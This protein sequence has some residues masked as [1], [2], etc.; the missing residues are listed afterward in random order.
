MLRGEGARR[1][2]RGRADGGADLRLLDGNPGGKPRAVRFD[3]TYRGYWT[4]IGHFIHSPFY[5]YAYAFGDCLVNALYA[6]FQRNPD[7]FQE[8]YLT[9]LASGGRYRHKE[10][11]AP[12]GLDASDPAFWN[13][14][15]DII[16]GM[17]D[18]LEGLDVA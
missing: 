8:K 10:L 17:I 3:D 11:L 13:Q 2:A 16:S 9:L 7:G 5:V 14:G 1:P 18:E 6:E 12:F 15:L 4:Y